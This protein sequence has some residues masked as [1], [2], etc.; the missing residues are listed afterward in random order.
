MLEVDHR[1]IIVKVIG[2]TKEVLNRTTLSLIGE[3]FIDNI[4]REDVKIVQNKSSE[5]SSQFESRIEIEGRG[6]RWFEISHESFTDYNNSELKIIIL[7]DI[8]DKKKILKK[9]RENES[10]Y[11]S[12]TENVQDIVVRIDRGLKIV[13]ANS[14][15]QSQLFGEKIIKSLYDLDIDS[16]SRRELCCGY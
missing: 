3:K 12:L 15:A 14:A 4:Y 7:K 6:L 1:G 10:L 9:I 13:Y 5:K 8:H 11:H 16:S 2:N